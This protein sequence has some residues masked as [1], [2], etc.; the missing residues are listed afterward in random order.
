[1]FQAAKDSRRNLTDDEI[2]GI[3]RE[4]IGN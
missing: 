1:V 4:R 3:V 2:D